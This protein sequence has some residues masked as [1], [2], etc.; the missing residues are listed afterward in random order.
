VLF[1]DAAGAVLLTPS[2]EPDSG[3]L[4]ADLAADGSHYDLI[5][6][7]A[8]GSRQPFRPGM[9]PKDL[10]MTMQDGKEMFTQAVKVMT[11]CAMRALKKAALTAADIHHFV[12]HQANARIFD[13]VCDK[14]D[15]PPSKT[16]R[17]IE[18]FGNS[19]AATIPLSLSLAHRAHPFR[20]G[21]RLLL[22]AA[23]AGL[24]GGAVVF[25]V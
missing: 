12:P 15:I 17:S 22:T 7:P 24:T 16:I 10:L 23:G 5:S 11:Q 9:N 1:A 3:L 13:A 19:S 8:G 4:G 14:L 20:R 21:E 25:A 18:E 2:A 6:I